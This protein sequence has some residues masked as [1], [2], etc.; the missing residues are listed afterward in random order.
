MAAIMTQQDTF[1]NRPSRLPQDLL[2]QVIS[3]LEA[4]Y[5]YNCT[6][7]E[8]Y[9]SA[10]A[11]TDAVIDFGLQNFGIATT[12]PGMKKA[13]QESAL[14]DKLFMERYI[15]RFQNEANQQ[16]I[17]DDLYEEHRF[18]L[19]T[20]QE[21]FKKPNLSYLL[22]PYAQKKLTEPLQ[23]IYDLIKPYVSAFAKH[24][25]QYN[26]LSYNPTSGQSGYVLQHG[27]TGINEYAGY[28]D[29]E[30]GKFARLGLGDVDVRKQKVKELG[31]YH[32]TRILFA[33][34][35][36]RPV[37]AINREAFYALYCELEDAKNAYK[38]FLA[39]RRVVVTSPASSVPVPATTKE[40]VPESAATVAQPAAAVQAEPQPAAVIPAMPFVSS[41]D[42]K[43]KA[44][45][46][47]QSFSTTPT[48]AESDLGTDKAAKPSLHFAKKQHVKHQRRKTAA[49]VKEAESKMKSETVSLDAQSTISPKMIKNLEKH[50]ETLVALFYEKSLKK[51][52]IAE[53]T[54]EAIFVMVGG[55]ISNREGSRKQLS[56]KG[57]LGF[58]SNEE[59]KAKTEKA[60]LHTKNQAYAGPEILAHYRDIFHRI[61]LAPYQLWPED[62]YKELPHRA[63]KT[64]RRHGMSKSST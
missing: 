28:I 24:F 36:E 42:L 60:H 35:A 34:A 12:H 64:F 62:G 9:E 19:F 23:E 5:H 50:R 61:G 3:L 14:K 46:V 47:Q 54:L 44:D 25:E 13:I 33:M 6:L 15:T 57:K 30:L 17:L 22:N 21:S 38:V 26:L 56:F 37:A 52:Q 51:L 59:N 48:T 16:K 27:M 31:N 43:A 63:T 7:L 20:L 2:A 29:K 39:A 1:A 18:S 41:D 49:K 45:A 40:T 10:D 4:N 55:K 32:F 11:E 53:N 58:V 8:F